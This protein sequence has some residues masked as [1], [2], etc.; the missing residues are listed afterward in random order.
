MQR[1]VPGPPLYCCS[2]PENRWRKLRQHSDDPQPGPRENDRDENRQRDQTEERAPRSDW[3]GVILGG[4]VTGSR[5]EPRNE[6][7]HQPVRSEQESPRHQE[8]D[9]RRGERLGT[10]CT[11]QPVGNVP[12]IELADGSEIECGHDEAKV[13]RKGE[14]AE[15]D[16]L[17]E[18]VAAGQR[19]DCREE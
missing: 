13:A 14:R 12:A 9:H 18:R 4:G 3:R 10:A 19:V 11:E 15:D 1:C 8:E 5:D 2:R 17:P 6:A 7:P 16:R